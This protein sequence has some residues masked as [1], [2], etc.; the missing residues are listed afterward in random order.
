[1]RLLDNYHPTDGRFLTFRA[2]QGNGGLGDRVVGLVSAF[3]LAVLT[4]RHFR[5]EWN[6]P[7]PLSTVWEPADVR[8][9]WNEAD[10]HHGHANLLSLIDRAAAFRRARPDA[11]SRA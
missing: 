4:D 3:V 5:I 2:N 11:V 1:M 7:F 6:T 8:I 9:A 10:C